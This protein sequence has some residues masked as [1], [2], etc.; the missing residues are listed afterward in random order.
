MNMDCR[1]V[2]LDFE[3]FISEKSGM[4]P[5]GAGKDTDENTVFHKAASEYQKRLLAENYVILT[6]C[7]LR[8]KL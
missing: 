1:R 3:A 4:E 8:L 5:S 7:C 6:I 2:R